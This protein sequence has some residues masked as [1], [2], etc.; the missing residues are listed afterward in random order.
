MCVTNDQ[1]RNLSEA[2]IGLHKGLPEATPTALVAWTLYGFAREIAW[3]RGVEV[4]VHILQNTE[5]SLPAVCFLAPG[6][7]TLKCPVFLVSD[8][9][10]ERGLESRV[11]EFEFSIVNFFCIFL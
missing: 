6:D 11:L 3:V 4:R 9:Y 7:F 2:L 8:S 10:E 1:W 5:C